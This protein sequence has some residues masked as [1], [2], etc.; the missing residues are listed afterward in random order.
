MTYLTVEANRDDDITIARI[1]ILFMMEHLRFQTAN[2]TVPLGYL[3]AVN[4]LDSAAQYDW[5]SAILASLYHG[6]DT[7]VTTGGAITAFV[8][9]LPYWFYEYYEVGHP[10]VKEEVT[11]EVRI[12]LD[13]LLS[14]SPHIS[15]AAL[16]EMRQAGFTDC[17]SHVDRFPEDGESRSVRTECT[18]SLYYT[19]GGYV[20]VEELWH[21]AHGMRRLDL[22]ESARDAQR[23]QEVEEEL[24]NAPRQI[25]S[26]DHQLYA[27][28]LQL[29][30]GYDVRVVSL[31]PGG[32]ARMRQHGFGLRTRGGSTSSRGWGTGDDSE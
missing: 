22:A 31:L 13:P 14:M 2:D 29:R 12:P 21:L 1:F 32:G 11:G 24:V 10:I 8:Q 3:A 15:P 16:H 6:L 25:H 17:R 23:I 27:H 28:D 20:S 18:Q 7:A 9:L 5:G 30:R 26:I 4:D 19:R